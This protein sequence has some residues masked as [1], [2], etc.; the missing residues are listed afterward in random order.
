M[1]SEVEEHDLPGIG[2]SFRVLSDSGEE[3]TVVVHNSGR[4]DLYILP[5]GEE[6]P[7]TLTLTDRQA[8]TIGALLSGERSAPPALTE[9]KR[10]VDDMVLDWAELTPGSPA[11]GQSLQDLRVQGTIGGM[12]LLCLVRGSNALHDPSETEPLKA[13]DRL[14]VAGRRENMALFRKVVVGEHSVSGR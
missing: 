8:R 14:V 13:G 2:R 3:L 1:D 10:I 5:E 11:T 9:V 12:T 4:R 6:E 7:T